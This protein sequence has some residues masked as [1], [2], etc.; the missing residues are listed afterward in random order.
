MDPEAGGGT[1]SKF[2]GGRIGE[3]R[4]GNSAGDESGVIP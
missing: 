2:D 4:F 3:D 1:K